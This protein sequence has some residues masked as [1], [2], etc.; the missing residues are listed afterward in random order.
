MILCI[1]GQFVIPIILGTMLTAV[2]LLLLVRALL[3]L[4][5]VEDSFLG[6]GAWSRFFIQ[7]LILQVM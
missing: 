4:V 1:C 6:K 2:V 7:S 5:E 3:W